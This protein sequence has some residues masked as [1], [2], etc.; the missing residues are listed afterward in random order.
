MNAKGKLAEL[1]DDVP[2]AVIRKTPLELAY[3]L[4][5]LDSIL[6]ACITELAEH[7]QYVRELA[8]YG[9][10]V[11]FTICTRALKAG[12][13][14]FGEPEFSALL[15]AEWETAPT[16]PWRAF[17]KSGVRAIWGA[18][19]IYGRQYRKLTGKE[20]SLANFTKAQEYLGKFVERP[21]PRNFQRLGKE[22]LK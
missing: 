6:H 19:E 12:G 16:A 22:L 1:F 4:Y 14:T 18:Y 5:V 17:C 20:P 15:E 10:F 21:V 9:R 2:Y 3:Q 7:T 13:A 11:L 8:S